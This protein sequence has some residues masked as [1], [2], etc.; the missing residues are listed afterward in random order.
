MNQLFS[1]VFCN[2]SRNRTIRRLQFYEIAGILAANRTD[3]VKRQCL[4]LQNISAYGAAPS[5]NLVS[6]CL[7]GRSLWRS[8]S[9]FLQMVIGIGERRC[10]GIQDFCLH[11]LTHNNHMGSHVHGGYNTA[12][13]PGTDAFCGIWIME[14]VPSMWN[15]V[16]F[17][18]ILAALETKTSNQIHFHIV[19]KYHRGESAGCLNQLKCIVFLVKSNG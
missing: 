4:R 7:I 17:F 10:L 12:G 1:G 14:T 16:V 3:K 2:S 6:V 5:G 11:C 8:G 13:E 19:G 9:V 15:A 18:H